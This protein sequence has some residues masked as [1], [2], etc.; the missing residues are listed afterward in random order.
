VTT[1]QQ[2]KPEYTEHGGPSTAEAEKKA[3]DNEQT[4]KKPEVQVEAT[5]E[6]EGE[7]SNSGTEE[8]HVTQW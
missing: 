7:P 8:P 1:D 6:A 3:P 4:G 5:P 2:K